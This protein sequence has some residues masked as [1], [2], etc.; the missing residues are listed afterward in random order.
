MPLALQEK[1][2]WLEQI[3]SALVSLINKEHET[4]GTA[5]EG[6]KE[7]ALLG[8]E[9]VQGFHWITRE[10]E[11]LHP[12]ASFE[13][14]NW[15]VQNGDSFD[16]LFQQEPKAF[17]HAPWNLASQIQ[18]FISQ[19]YIHYFFWVARHLYNEK[20]ML[21][22]DKVF[23]LLTLLYPQHADFWIW[24]GLC[25]QQRY[26][27]ELAL[28]SHTIA[29]VLDSQNPYPFYYLA[30]CWVQLK[31]WDQAKNNLKECLDK[32]GTNP[33]F[34]RVKIKCQEIQEAILSEPLVRENYRPPIVTFQKMALHPGEAINNVYLN[35]SEDAPFTP[36]IL[37]QWET[38]FEELKKKTADLA[39]QFN[40][41]KESLKHE[42]NTFDF[43]ERHSIT[44]TQMTVKIPLTSFSQVYTLALGLFLGELV[45]GMSISADRKMIKGE[46]QTNNPFRIA[47]KFSEI[48]D[49]SEP[50]LKKPMSK[51]VYL[52]NKQ[53]DITFNQEVVNPEYGSSQTPY[54]EN[55]RE[56]NRIRVAQFLREDI[57]GKSILDCGCNE[58]GILFACRNLGA[59][60][61][62][63]FDINSWC[64]SQANGLVSTQKITDAKFYVGD[65]ENRAFLSM[66][67]MSDTVLLL[68]VLD[69]S[70][71]VNKM[72]VISNLSRFAKYTF[73]YEGHV[74]PESHVSRMYEF[75]IATDFTRFEYFGRFEGRILLR[76]TRD[77]I[78]KDQLPLNAITS[79][80]TDAALLSASE[81]YLFTDSPRN[82]PFSNKCRLIQF[83][84]R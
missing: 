39:N 40:R 64:I 72:A 81:I 6:E 48:L 36:L 55:K 25:Q 35:Q 29:S 23:R 70:I 20:E 77:L 78:E 44:L 46:I 71:F 7:V 37:G 83:V 62:T 54:Q 53:M 30:Q 61:I 67:P 56:D 24:L 82:S 59:K 75:L 22:A 26:L 45:A 65:I 5:K 69:T 42:I 8:E 73:Y 28:I 31:G 49:Q 79:D 13:F 38:L 2:R 3:S 68:A 63:G 66:L 74:T 1:M 43:F 57:I 12:P 9:L 47:Y 34:Q 60:T 16:K 15:A 50:A 84:K 58:G 41:I 14:Y 52:Y 76:C 17:E 11:K 80:A 18:Q 10:L 33:S 19:K 51:Y 27:P 21:K 32:I 4:H